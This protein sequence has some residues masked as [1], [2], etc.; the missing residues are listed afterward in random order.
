KDF[1]KRLDFFKSYMNVKNI[2]Y[3][4]IEKKLWFKM[5]NKSLYHLGNRGNEFKYNEKLKQ[6]L[7][8]NNK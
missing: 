3:S 7:K 8:E 2:N 5:K 1:Y 6:N 4:R